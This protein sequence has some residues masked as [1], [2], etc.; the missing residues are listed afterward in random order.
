MKILEIKKYPDKILRKESCAVK[1]ITEKE[2]SLFE[3]MLF[4]MRHFSGIGLAAPQIGLNQRLIVV[5]VGEGSFKLAN[6]EVIR[7]KGK[8][9]MEEG[10]LSVPGVLIEITRPQEVVVRGL[11][12]NGKVVE[13]NAK[14]LLARALLHEI[15]HLNGKLVVDYMNLL[16]RMKFKLCS[17]KSCGS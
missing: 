11:N 9:K 1:Q 6:P 15:D 7:I 3:D 10:C 13:I 14:G 12:E 8:D 5:D 16:Q 2:I 4:T 17:K